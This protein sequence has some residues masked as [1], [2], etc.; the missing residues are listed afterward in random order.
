M[1]PPNNVVPLRG[2]TPAS[3]NI[4]NGKVSPPPRKTNQEVRSREFLTGNEVEQLIVAA[5]GLGRHAH[6]DSTLIL[7]AYRH[8]G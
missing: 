2:N 8:V 3:P 5:K 7:I 4:E 1:Q 6:R